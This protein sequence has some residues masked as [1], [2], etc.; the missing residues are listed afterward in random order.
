MQNNLV[1]GIITFSLR[2]KLRAIAASASNTWGLFWL[3][4]LLGYGLVEVPRSIWHS[5]STLHTLNHSY[6]RAAKLSQERAET[7]ERV[8]DLLQVSKTTA[9]RKTMMARGLLVFIRNQFLGDIVL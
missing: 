3:V 4:L 6:F 7:S 1:S 9:D 2:A 5:A 8:S